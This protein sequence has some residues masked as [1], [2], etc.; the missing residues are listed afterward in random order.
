[1][2]CP[3]AAPQLTTTGTRSTA[4]LSRRNVVMHVVYIPSR[5]VNLLPL[6]LLLMNLV[7]NVHLVLVRPAVVV[8]PRARLG[9]DTQAKRSSKEDEE[10]GAD[11]G[12]GLGRGVSSLPHPLTSNQT[13][14]NSSH[15]HSLRSARRVHRRP[16]RVRHSRRGAVVRRPGVRP[17]GGVVRVL[18]AVRRVG[19]ARG[20]GDRV[21]LAL[22]RG[23]SRRRARLEARQSAGAAR[24]C[25]PAARRGARLPPAAS[26]R[27]RAAAALRG[28]RCC[29][30]RRWIHHRGRDRARCRRRRGLG[31]RARRRGYS[32]TTQ[33]R[34]RDLSLREAVSI[35]SRQSAS[36]VSRRTLLCCLARA[37][38]QQR[39]RTTRLESAH[40]VRS[41]GPSSAS[42]CV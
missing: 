7:A 16:S 12:A 5:P 26:G 4:D 6:P 14:H 19:V 39:P 22:L 32:A 38:P 36:L 17:A 33:R 3:A 31:R 18:D 10:H 21:R 28:C 2:S 13:H 27:G 11:D 9:S 35:P 24:V 29:R 23:Q 8:P 41:V 1:M 25:E 15:P 40:G 30:T 42:W 20:R 37:R 34:R